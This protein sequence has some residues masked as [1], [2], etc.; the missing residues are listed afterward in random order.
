MP[1]V[2]AGPAG[3]HAMTVALPF[4]GDLPRSLIFIILFR[5]LRFLLQ[6]QQTDYVGKFLTVSFVQGHQGAMGLQ[7]GLAQTVSANAREW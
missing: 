4:L 7:H 6:F 3:R 1:D 5:G 2:T